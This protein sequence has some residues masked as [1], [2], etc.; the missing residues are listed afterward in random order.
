MTESEEQAYLRGERAAW[1][2]LLA[3]AVKHLGY[4]TEDGKLAALLSEREQVVE[5]LR[6]VCEDH[7]DNDWGAELHLADVIEKHL[8][9]HLG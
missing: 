8:R 6:Q 9:R 2:N 4:D 3:D 7:G 5:A 1:R